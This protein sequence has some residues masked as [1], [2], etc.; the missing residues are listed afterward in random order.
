MRWSVEVVDSSWV[1]NSTLGRLR[2]LGGRAGGG[3]GRATLGEASGFTTVVGLEGRDFLGAAAAAGAGGVGA[4]LLDALAVFAA[5]LDPFD[6]F[7]A[8]AAGVGAGAEVSRGGDD[9]AMA[10]V[11]SAPHL[12]PGAKRDSTAPSSEVWTPVLAHPGAS[13]GPGGLVLWRPLMLRK[14][15]PFSLV[16]CAAACGPDDQALDKDVDQD[17]VEVDMDAIAATTIRLE[18]P[19]DGLSGAASS[20][21]Y[22]AVAVPAGATRLVVTLDGPNGDADIYL[23]FNRYPSTSTYDGRSDGSTSRERIEVRAPQRGTWYV[24]LRG[25]GAFSGARLLVSTQA[26]PSASPSPSPSASATPSPTP[27]AALEDQVLVLVNQARTGG[28]TC[29]G[30]AMPAVPAL[31]MNAQLR[32]AARA[33]SADMATQDYF[34]HVGQDGRTFAQRIVDSG[35]SGGFPRAENIAAGR[36][37]AAQVM[38]QWMT[39]PGHCRNIMGAGYRSIGVGYATSA[40]STYRHYWTQDFG[41]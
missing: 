23:R 8:F 32:A 4:V 24:M 38:E 27:G 17:L 9:R 39:S 33:H 25:Y 26:A 21:R 36:A 7:A 11:R 30:V 22:F 18:R 3:A 41:G 19:V 13:T 28:A 31:T 1:L 29:D 35:F 14:L 12:G 34:S 5:A 40:A 6:P 37:T 20:A 16:L 10:P 15:L 2:R